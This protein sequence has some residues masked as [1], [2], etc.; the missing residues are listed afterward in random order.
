M[1]EREEWKGGRERD[2][3]RKRSSEKEGWR[4]RD[5]GRKRGREKRER[6]R[7]TEG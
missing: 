7:K 3:R 2:R 6:G 5:K 4:E 1:R